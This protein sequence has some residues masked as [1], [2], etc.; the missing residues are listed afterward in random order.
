MDE[1]SLRK[2]IQERLQQRLD[3]LGL[4]PSDLTNDMDLVRG[5]VLDSLGFVDLMAELES[6]T[7]RQVDLESALEGRNATT[8][9]AIITLFSAS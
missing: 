2:L 6:T 1:S 3:R 9:G 8:V 5:G 7:G 4:K